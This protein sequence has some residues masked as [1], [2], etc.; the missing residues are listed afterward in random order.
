MTS[1]TPSVRASPRAFSTL[2]R[3]ETSSL[4]AHERIGG[5][6]WRAVITGI[7]HAVPDTILT[8]QELER[9]VETSD[10]WIVQRTGIRER[11]IAG[12]NDTTATLSTQAVKNLLAKR[13]FNPADVD[14]VICATV[15][16]D[17]MF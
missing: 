13:Q 2:E 4:Y 12:E 5:H 7:A 1:W 11:R 10:E 3:L 16:G 9:M 15:T 8:N 14:I 6:S 17:M